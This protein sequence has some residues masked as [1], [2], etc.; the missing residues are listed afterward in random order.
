MESG[1][2]EK[3]N[4]FFL[5]Y[6]IPKNTDIVKKYNSNAASVYRD[7]IVALADGKTWR[8]PRF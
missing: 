8:D 7:R 3:L 4:S 1:G 6:G 2:N 5:Q